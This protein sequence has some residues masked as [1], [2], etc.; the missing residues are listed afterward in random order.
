MSASRFNVF[1]RVYELRREAGAWRALAV[2]ND[3]KLGPAGFEVPSFI[4]DDELEQFL[5][6]FFHES[7]TPGNGDVRRLPG[8]HGP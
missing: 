2:G 3:G 7:A 6:D 8:R 1:G 4:E 5:F